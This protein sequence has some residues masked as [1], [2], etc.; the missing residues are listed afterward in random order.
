MHAPLAQGFIDLVN[1]K[2]GGDIQRAL[3]EPQTRSFAKAIGLVD[4]DALFKAELSPD[5]LDLI[6]KVL[7]DKSEDAVSKVHTVRLLLKN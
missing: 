3:F 7:N 6:R 5:R 4:D 1:S 2:Y